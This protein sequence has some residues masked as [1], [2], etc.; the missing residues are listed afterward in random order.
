MQLESGGDYPRFSGGTGGTS[1]RM[2]RGRLSLRPSLAIHW[3]AP[4]A[5]ASARGEAPVH[6]DSS[7]TQVWVMPTNEELV[8]ARQAAELLTGSKQG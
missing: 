1:F 6:A 8:V 7:R 2:S 4:A 3:D 5:N